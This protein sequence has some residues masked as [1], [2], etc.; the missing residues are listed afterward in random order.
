MK[1]ILIIGARGYGREYHEVIK[2][3]PQYGKKFVIKGFLD[4]KSTAL[5]GFAGYAP[6]LSSVEDYQIQKYDIFVCALGDSHAKAKYID[7]IKKKGGHFISLVHPTAIVYDTAELG[8]GVIICPFCIISANV[9]IGDF[10]TVQPFSNFGHD[11]QIGK[12]CSIE[13]YSFLGGFTQ[14]GD[15]ATLHTRSTILPHIKI[16]DNAIVGAGSVVIK[17]VKPNTTVF[18]VPAKKIEF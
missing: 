10:T 2:G 11:S 8:E 5:D 18:G 15:Y 9:K 12:F 4:D 7:I 17:N 1:N 3:Y 13:S 16:G 6:I 14:I